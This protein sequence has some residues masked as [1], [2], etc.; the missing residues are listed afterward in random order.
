MS[1]SYPRRLR[2]DETWLNNPPRATSRLALLQ[3]GS[4][5]SSQNRHRALALLFLLGTLSPFAIARD[6]EYELEQTT[7]DIQEIGPRRST[8][9]AKEREL[10]SR[11]QKLPAKTPETAQFEMELEAFRQLISRLAEEEQYLKARLRE[12]QSS[13]RYLVPKAIGSDKR[14][15]TKANISGVWTSGP[16][17]TGYTIQLEQRG[18]PIR[19][20]WHSWRVSG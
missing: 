15:P 10:R 11:L 17:L 6:I 7:K 14:R 12:I 5:Y 1:A 18:E 20:V 9:E 13:P 3:D 4:H 8:A 19:G 2:R 16:N